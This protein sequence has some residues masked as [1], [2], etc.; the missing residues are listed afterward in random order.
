MPVAQ[1]PCQLCLDEEVISCLTHRV[2][3]TLT[4]AKDRI[5]NHIGFDLVIGSGRE[6]YICI[7]HISAHLPI[8]ADEKIKSGKSLSPDI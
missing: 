5:V 4:Y 6:Y 2:Y 1:T 3:N 7:S 8:N